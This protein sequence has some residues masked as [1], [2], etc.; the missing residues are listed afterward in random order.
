MESEEKG[1]EIVFYV[2]NGRM[3]SGWILG[4]ID[5]EVSVENFSGDRGDM[6]KKALFPESRIEHEE[7]RRLLEKPG[8]WLFLSGYQLVHASECFNSQEEAAKD[9][10][11]KLLED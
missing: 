6:V 11:E 3:K 1:R 8:V 7:L 10:Y 2:Q 4:T 9:F 5:F